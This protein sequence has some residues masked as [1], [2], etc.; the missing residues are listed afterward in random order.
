MDLKYHLIIKF[1]AHLTVHGMMTSQTALK[2]CKQRRIP[3]VID[4][5]WCFLEFCGTPSKILNGWLEKEHALNFFLDNIHNSIQ[6]GNIP[7][8]LSIKLKWRQNEVIRY[9]CKIG[10]RLNDGD[11]KRTCRSDGTW[12]G[13]QPSCIRKFKMFFSSGY[14]C[15]TRIR[16]N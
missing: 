5:T 7:S 9:R 10:F 3:F 12:T 15:S 14:S 6:Y 8:P 2:V 16:S 11:E 4:L 1:S 13:V